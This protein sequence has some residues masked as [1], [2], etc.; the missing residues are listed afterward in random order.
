VATPNFVIQEE[1]RGLVEWYDEVVQHPIVLEN[2]RW[3]VPTSP[4]LG[5]EL[6]ERAAAKHPFEPEVIPARE[7]R[8][9]DG[10]ILNW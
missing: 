3:A 2:G 8:S 1:A 6:D 9:A 5:V 10:A 7:A 4:G